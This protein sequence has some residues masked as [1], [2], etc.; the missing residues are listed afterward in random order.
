MKK[1]YLVL[2][3]FVMALAVGGAC[4]SQPA[5]PAA[6]TITTSAG[7]LPSDSP[8]VELVKVKRIYIASFGDDPQAKQIEAMVAAALAESKRFIVTENKDKADAILQG[9]GNEKTSQE[10]HSYTDKTAAGGFAGASSV[11]YGSGSGAIAGHSA[12]IEDSGTSTETVDRASVA[13][14]LVDRD[15]D[16]IWSTK[17]DSHGAKYKS[18]TA[19]VADKIV[20]Q[21][22]WA[23]ERA[24]RAVSAQ[25]P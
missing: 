16:V 7:S 6:P 15:G 1:P 4:Q 2:P 14:R 11:S 23:V 17:Q 13:V 24:E 20:K 9:A 19:D 25:K 18:A 22:T 8:Q 10:L 5:A 21:L 12:A 3:L